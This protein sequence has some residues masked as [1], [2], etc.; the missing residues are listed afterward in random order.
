[1][2][3]LEAYDPPPS[4]EYVSG[5]EAELLRTRKELA[6]ALEDRR[7]AEKQAVKWQLIGD[8]FQKATSWKPP[9][10]P[11]P[12]RTPAT[13]AQG[14]GKVKAEERSSSFE[15]KLKSEENINLV[16]ALTA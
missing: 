2:F 5:I 14:G 1:M 4:R 10:P 6:Q 15:G 12:P 8:L 9:K 7:Y 13:F 11:S 3:A 16:G